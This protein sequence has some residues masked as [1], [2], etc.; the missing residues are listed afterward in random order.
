[1]ASWRKPRYFN[2]IG[3]ALGIVMGALMR[4]IPIGVV[5]GVALAFAIGAFDERRRRAQRNQP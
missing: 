1:V 3:L 2:P 5:V 4:N